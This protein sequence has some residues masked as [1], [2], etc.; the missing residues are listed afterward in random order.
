MKFLFDFE[1]G[2][3]GEGE[4]GH[5]QSAGGVEGCEDCGGGKKWQAKKKDCEGSR[6]K[7][8]GA[9]DLRI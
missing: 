6:G 9:W 8:F 7:M 1:E 5:G 3:E 4:W 2:A